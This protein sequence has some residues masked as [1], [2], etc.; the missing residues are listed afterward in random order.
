MLH[1]YCNEKAL[2]GKTEQVGEQMLVVASGGFDEV[3]FLVLW[4]DVDVTEFAEVLIESEGGRYLQAFH[5]G[6]A[7]AISETPAFISIRRKRDSRS[8]NIV[9]RDVFEV[10]CRALNQCRTD[11]KCDIGIATLLEQC[12]KFIDDIVCRR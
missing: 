8:C 6:P 3:D 2:I 1:V 11:G 10:A 4:Y 12:K 9:W 7:G 5:D